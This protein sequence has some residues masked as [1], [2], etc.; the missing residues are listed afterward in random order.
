MKVDFMG[1]KLAYGRS[2]KEFAKACKKFLVMM[3]YLEKKR[4][5]K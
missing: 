2:P 5:R 4:K 1:Q 3:D